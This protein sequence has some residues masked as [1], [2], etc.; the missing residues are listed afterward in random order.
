MG[1]VTLEEVT[2]LV[3]E[4]VTD[5]TLEVA[6]GF[7]IDEM[8]RGFG[9]SFELPATDTSETPRYLFEL[10]KSFLLLSYLKLPSLSFRPWFNSYSFICLMLVGLVFTSIFPKELYLF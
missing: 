1:S 9:M 3:L 2:R 6:M 8:A 4:A 10:E 5:V 7:V